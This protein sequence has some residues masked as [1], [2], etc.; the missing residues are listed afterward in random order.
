MQDMS[1]RRRFCFV[2]GLGDLAKV[3]FEL[4]VLKNSEI[5]T[6]RFSVKSP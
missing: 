3:G 2:K 6:S 1:G 4:I 5:L